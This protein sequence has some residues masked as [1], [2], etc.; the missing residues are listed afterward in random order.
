MPEIIEESHYLPDH[1]TCVIKAK[2]EP[3]RTYAAWLNTDKFEN[4]RDADG[5]PALPYLLIFQTKGRTP[6]T[7]EARWREDIEFF[8][9]TLN[10]GHR[11]F[12]KLVSRESF[13]RDLS[14][15]K[16][17]AEHLSDSEIIIRLMREVASLG[18]A[19]A[20]LDWRSD[21]FDFHFYPLRLHW[22]GDGLARRRA[23]LPTGSGT[24]A[25]SSFA[26][27]GT[28][29]GGGAK[30][31]LPSSLIVRGTV[32]FSSPGGTAPCSVLGLVNL[33]FLDTLTF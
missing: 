30:A 33:E 7:R 12:A 18:V 11:D 6:A 26:T 20:T 5:T 29:G 31:I 1:R 2:L 28:G 14:E 25:S 32:A 24:P 15:L 27:S 8:A 3:G 23:A 10:S 21:K 9:T 13:K 16:S 4:F 19:H 22:F 17:G